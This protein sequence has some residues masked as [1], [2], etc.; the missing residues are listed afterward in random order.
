[1]KNIEW[2]CLD[3]T[4]I[5]LLNKWLNKVKPDMVIHCAAIV[6]V[7][8]CEDNVEMATR[9]HVETTEVIAN[10]LDTNNGRLIYISTD[11]VF[12]GK[13]QT[14]YNE[15]DLANP[16]NIYARTKLMGEQP[17]LSMVNG[18]I[19]R[20][21]IIGWTQEGNTSFAE[22]VIRGLIDNAPLNL[23]YDVHFS[24]LHVD[25][26]SLIIKNIIER[27]VYGLYHFASSDN[28]SKY[29]FGVQM[30][31]VFGLSDSNINRASVEDVDFK[32]ERP[33]NMALNSEKLAEK[34]KRDMFSAIDSIKLMKRQYDKNTRLLN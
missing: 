29:D 30:A 13:K 20:T 4:D 10:Y 34:L 26:L 9:L 14:P 17:V 8:A 25:E 23:F 33:K 6:N 22:W 5:P 18:L 15:T 21:N 19:L 31:K 2:D 1:G 27:P 12:D 32:A 28:I 11:S 7:D 24:P 3:L 16:L